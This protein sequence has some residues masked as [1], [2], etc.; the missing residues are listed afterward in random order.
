MPAF[1]SRGFREVV[2]KL[3]DLSACLVSDVEC[4]G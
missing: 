4:V 1:G 3:L 2:A